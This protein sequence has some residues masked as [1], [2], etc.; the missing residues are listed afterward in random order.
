MNVGKWMAF[1]MAVMALAGKITA[2]AQAWVLA[3]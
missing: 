2:F 1:L 3:G